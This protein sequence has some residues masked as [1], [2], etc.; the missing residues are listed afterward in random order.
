MVLSC[1]AYGE[2]VDNVEA[3][4]GNDIVLTS[5]IRDMAFR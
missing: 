3:A 4:T 1:L 5:F 2:I